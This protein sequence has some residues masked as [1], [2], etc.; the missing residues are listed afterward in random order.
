MSVLFITV[1]WLNRI[2][3][4]HPLTQVGIYKVV[5]NI[6]GIAVNQ[7]KEFT[8]SL[9]KNVLEGASKDDAEKAKTELETAG[10]KVKIA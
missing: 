8:A 10:A 9:P 3:A 4:A 5:R 1:P 2:C 6:A 7:V